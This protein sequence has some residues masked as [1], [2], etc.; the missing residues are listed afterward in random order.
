M[1]DRKCIQRKIRAAAAVRG[2]GGGGSGKHD[3][4]ITAVSFTFPVIG[5]TYQ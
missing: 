2:G 4:L 5:G 3:I 1:A